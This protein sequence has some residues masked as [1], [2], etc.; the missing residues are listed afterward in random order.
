MGDLVMPKA[1]R[2]GLE[3]SHETSQK[4]AQWVPSRWLVVVN[5]NHPAARHDACQERV[6]D[7]TFALIRNLMQE[8]EAGHSIIDA[9]A[10]TA[11]IGDS[12]LGLREGSKLAS[13]QRDLQRHQVYDIESAAAAHPSG[14]FR[15]ETAIDVGHMQ[16]PLTRLDLGKKSPPQS[17]VVAQ[18][19]GAHHRVAVKQAGI[20]WVE[21]GPT[22]NLAQ[23][24]RYHR[25]VV[26]Q[27]LR[28]VGGSC[29]TNKRIGIHRS[30]LGRRHRRVLL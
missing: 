23:I 4:P 26:R 22:V 3:P 30:T 18:Q 5:E 10:R 11:G 27:K 25:Y 17:A 2:K 9:I 13:T 20:G 24:G 12:Y 28:R 7:G 19:D 21:I 1:F 6:D 15:N 29:A 8:K 16:H 14:Q